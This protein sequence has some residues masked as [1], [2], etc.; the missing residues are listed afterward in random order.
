M[1]KRTI[2]LPDRDYQ[3]TQAEL[4]EKIKLDLP[5]GTAMEKMENLARAV[6]RPVSIRYRKGR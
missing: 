4:N 2:T 5:G 6:T 1:K 3:P